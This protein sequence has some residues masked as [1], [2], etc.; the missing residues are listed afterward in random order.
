MSTGETLKSGHGKAPTPIPTRRVHISHIISP[1]HTA[2]AGTVT[3]TT[4]INTIAAARRAAISGT[5]GHTQWLRATPHKPSWDERNAWRRSGFTLLISV[6]A[7]RMVFRLEEL[8][9][10]CQ[11]A[12]SFRHVRYAP[13][14]TTRFVS[15]ITNGGAILHQMSTS[16]LFLPLHS[17]T[18]V[19]ISGAVQ[20]DS[21]SSTSM[22]FQQKGYSASYPSSSTSIFCSC[23]RHQTAW[24]LKNGKDNKLGFGYSI[25][26]SPGYGLGVHLFVLTALAGSWVNGLRDGQTRPWETGEAFIYF[27]C[28]VGM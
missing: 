1:V 19:F 22:A 28:L 12:T 7:L 2:R 8:L 23:M 27:F 26:I 24:G 20:S 9:L 4:C 5:T 3:G 18:A 16:S 15:S 14:L 21:E 13:R 11:H 17:E 6:L 25:V 10:R